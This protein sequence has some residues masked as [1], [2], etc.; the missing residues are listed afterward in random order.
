MIQC[1]DESPIKRPT[2]SEIYN[3][4]KDIHNQLGGI[5]LNSSGTSYLNEQN[6]EEGYLWYANSEGQT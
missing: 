3:K 5:S 1:W 2:F 6:T 4:M